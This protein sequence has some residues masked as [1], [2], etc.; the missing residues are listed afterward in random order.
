[1]S[2]KHESVW[3]LMTGLLELGT[4][5]TFLRTHVRVLSGKNLMYVHH[6]AMEERVCFECLNSLIRSIVLCTS[7]LTPTFPVST[8]HDT[9][10]HGTMQYGVMGPWAGRSKDA[11]PSPRSP[12]HA[13]NPR[14]LLPLQW[15]C[16][17]YR[18][19]CGCTTCA[20]PTYASHCNLEWPL[21][22]LLLA[23]REGM[24]RPTCGPTSR[25][26]RSARGAP[27]TGWSI[28]GAEWKC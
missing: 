5:S 23:R 26:L 6:L 12:C 9:M 13:A 15:P 14:R 8:W 28:R 10:L 1:M 27:G 3:E 4:P 24:P 2:Q 19:P 18:V 17:I 21:P 22:L 11:S 20:S 25:H 7:I 16:A